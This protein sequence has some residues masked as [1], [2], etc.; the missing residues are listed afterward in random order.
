ME[1]EKSLPKALPSLTATASAI[2]SEIE[3]YR[4]AARLHQKRALRKIITAMILIVLSALAT[5]ALVAMVFLARNGKIEPLSPIF[6]YVT[7]GAILAVLLGGLCFFVGS[8]DDMGL[9]SECLESIEERLAQLEEIEHQIEEEKRREEEAKMRVVETLT[10]LPMTRSQRIAHAL[11][12]TSALLSA[13][14]IPVA[15]LAAFYKE[16]RKKK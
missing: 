2:Q 13:L 6:L 12:V 15:A 14:S 16:Q 11:R 4:Q 5:A 10:S 1:E 7:S 9:A 3:L 8:R